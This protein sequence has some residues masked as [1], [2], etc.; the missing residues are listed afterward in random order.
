[1]LSNT[2]PQPTL[3]PTLN[4][5]LT[6][7]PNHDAGTLMLLPA[8]PA[9]PTDIAKPNDGSDIT[10]N[11]SA[12]GVV[13]VNKG[14]A[15]QLGDQPTVAA[16]TTDSPW[17][18]A[19]ALASLGSNSNTSIK[20][21][22]R[23]WGVTQRSSCTALMP[24]NPIFSDPKSTLHL[25]DFAKSL[26]IEGVATVLT[27][28]IKQTG[29]DKKQP[30]TTT[31][32]VVRLDEQDTLPVDT[33]GHILNSRTEADIYVTIA[34]NGACTCH[35]CP[36]CL[37]AY[38]ESTAKIFVLAAKPEPIDD[39]E[40]KVDVTAISNLLDL[41]NGMQ[42]TRTVEERVQGLIADVTGGTVDTTQIVPLCFQDWHEPN[43]R[44]D[45]H[46]IV[47]ADC[48]STAL[49]LETKSKP[50]GVTPI[51]CCHDVLGSHLGK[52]MVDDMTWVLYEWI[53]E[54][55]TRQAAVRMG[56]HP[57]Y[58]YIPGD[59]GIFSGWFDRAEPPSGNWIGFIPMTNSVPKRPARDRKS[60]V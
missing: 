32:H 30:P 36:T 56:K 8:E 38:D 11:T 31:T 18:G 42:E 49:L 3:Q 27:V 10:A 52:H 7:A 54:N 2:A 20:V 53:F 40:V 47:Y 43:Q 48:I 35:N 57:T 29:S 39:H 12:P 4:L 23:G 58:N 22:G 59:D 34:V 1:M 60:V 5:E 9:V 44:P 50:D 19:V 26:M 46:I 55:S 51:W 28:N 16:P 45:L 37:S 41:S 24:R 6:D 15:N 25:T 33:H 13:N 21:S 17:G 14:T